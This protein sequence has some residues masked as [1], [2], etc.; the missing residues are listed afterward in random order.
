MEEL[1]IY[2]QKLVMYAEKFDIYINQLIVYIIYIENLSTY[3]RISLPQTFC[4]KE[5]ITC[6]QD[7]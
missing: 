6:I 2:M 1:V 3:I 4:T 5:F 7:N